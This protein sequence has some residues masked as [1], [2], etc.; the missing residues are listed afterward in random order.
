MHSRID[1]WMNECRIQK[2]EQK[3]RDRVAARFL[4]RARLAPFPAKVRPAVASDIKEGKVIWYR[5]GPDGPHWILVVEHHAGI[6]YWGLPMGG[7]KELRSIYSAYVEVEAVDPSPLPEPYRMVVARVLKDDGP[8]GSYE[9][10]P[11]RFHSFTYNSR[12]I[13]E[14]ADGHVHVVPADSIHFTTGLM[15]T[16]TDTDTPLEY[17]TDIEDIGDFAGREL[18]DMLKPATQREMVEKLRAREVP[19]ED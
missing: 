7:D 4:E 11:F 16:D 19:N 5:K 17:P 2:E 10:K 14:D 3:K 9:D 8:L 6:Y 12:A 18:W 1:K 15:D 13:I